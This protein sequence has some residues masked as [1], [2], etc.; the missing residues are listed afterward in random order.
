MYTIFN[1]QTA[2]M[3]RVK[4]KKCHWKEKN[5]GDLILASKFSWLI[6][7]SQIKYLIVLL[8]NIEILWR[9]LHTLSK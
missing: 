5:V 6:Y 1:N 8:S 9:M 4:K 3:A 7:A 2:D